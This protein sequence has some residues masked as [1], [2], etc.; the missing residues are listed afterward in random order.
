MQGT[1]GP[2]RSSRAGLQKATCRRMHC[3]ERP[4]GAAENDL[5]VCTVPWGGRAVDLQDCKRGFMGMQGVVG[6]PR[7]G[8]AGLQKTGS[9]YTMCH[10][11]WWR[12][13]ARL[14]ETG[15]IHARSPGAAV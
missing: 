5:Q 13:P 10:G 8:L 1:L 4:C 11:R 2:L 9:V 3:V 6:V 14:R 12:T 15:G 7:S